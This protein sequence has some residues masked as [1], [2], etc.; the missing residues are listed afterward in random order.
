MSVFNFNNAME[1]IEETMKL[2]SVMGIDTIKA[3]LNKLDNPQN[4]CKVIHIAG[5]NGKGSTLA[6]LSTILTKA[7]YKVGRYVSPT[8][9]HYLERIQINGEYISEAAF[10][11]IIYRIKTISEA[12]ELTPTAF[13]VETAAA[14]MYFK[15]QKCD[16]VVLETGLGGRYDAT[17][18]CDNTMCCV[19]TSIGLDHMGILGST[20]KEIATTKA[21][22][23]KKH[24]RVV[25]TIQAEEVMGVLSDKCNEMNAALTVSKPDILTSQISYSLEDTSYKHSSYGDI[26]LSLPGTYQLTNSCLVMS[27]IDV[28]KDLGYNISDKHVRDGLADTKWFGRFCVIGDKPLFILDGA[29]NKPA[30]KVLGETV[31]AYLNREFLAGR[32]L[33]YIMG[34]FADK[35]SE[36]IINETVPYA[37]FVFTIETPD[38]PRAMDSQILAGKISKIKPAKSC[39]SI[40]EAVYE[41]INYNNGN[42]VVLAF[43]SLSHLNKIREEYNNG[44]K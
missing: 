3:L 8:L 42:V 24:S 26:R 28:L 14:F 25:T 1:Y 39:S 27:V 23:I 22:I 5:T 44:Q 2:G 11:D 4:D 21:G 20:L 18:V 41:A 19:F 36:A 34:I 16:L 9:V 31:N 12:N 17:N 29:H 15:E 30:A 7:G 10:A 6:M 13:E 43:G 35:D 33:V 38:N 37:D 32:K 40:K